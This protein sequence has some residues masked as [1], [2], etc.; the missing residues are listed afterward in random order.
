[1]PVNK[2]QLSNLLTEMEKLQNEYKGK[3]MPE[4]VGQKFDSLMT[5]AKAMQDAADAEN[6][7]REREEKFANMQRFARQVPNPT[8][9]GAE[10]KSDGEIVGYI[11]PGHL[12]V[13]SEEYNRCIKADGSF[14]KNGVASIDIKGSLFKNNGLVALTQDEVKNL[15]TVGDAVSFIERAQ[16]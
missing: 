13:M 2:E 12:A 3:A 15:R 8:L 4:D 16:G 11:T 7:Q 1:M 5:E 10:S 6:K 9:P 14:A